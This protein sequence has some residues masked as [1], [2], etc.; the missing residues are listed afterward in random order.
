[1][2][3]IG[4]V[5]GLAWPS[6]AEYYRLLCSGAN[7]RF[8]RRGHPEPCPSPPMVIESLDISVTRRARG[9]PG[10]EASWAGYDTLFRD[11]FHRLH[12]AGAEVGLVASN[13]PHVRWPAISA[14]CRLTLV[15]ILDATA[16]AVRN[17]GARR[18]LVLGTPVT[19]RS[20]IYADALA[21][22]GIACLP[23]P[24]DAVVDALGALIDNE[25][26][27][28]QTEIAHRWLLQAAHRFGG[29]DRGTAVC[30]ACTELPLAFTGH[31]DDTAFTV[32]GIT[33]V[34]TTTAHVEA[35]LARSLGEA[36]DAA[37]TTR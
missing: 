9:R 6:T 33:F 8:R 30:L 25:L 1:M 31:R 5:G 14:D 11:A 13:T 2:K 22:C 28:G 29:G 16:K 10:D 12:Q 32:D 27:R 24:D 35:V 19:M 18:A 34:N 36:P 37:V 7:A 17:L 26:Y 15:S 21:R 23:N 4:V 3:K 20:R